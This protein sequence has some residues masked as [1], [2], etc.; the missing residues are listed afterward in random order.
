MY[1]LQKLLC[2]FLVSVLLAVTAYAADPYVRFGAPESIGARQGGF[3]TPTPL[4]VIVRNP[5]ARGENVLQSAG[6]LGQTGGAMLVNTARPEKSIAKLTTKLRYDRTQE[7]GSRLEVTVGEDKA[8]L[9]LYDWELRPLAEFVNSGHH[10]AIS[11]SLSGQGERIS[12][13][14][15]FEQQLLGLRFIQADLIARNIVLSQEFLP[16]DGQGL[17]LGAGEKARLGTDQS[18]TAAVTELTPLMSRTGNAAPFSVLTDA[19]LAFTFAIENGRFVVSG[20]PRYIFWHPNGN[21]VVQEVRVNA[22]L[23]ASWA[24]LKQANP[25]VIESMERSF[26]AVALFRFQKQKQLANWSAF[27]K[28][29]KEIRLQKVPTP[30]SLAAAQAGSLPLRTTP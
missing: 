23:N 30:T 17:I 28:Q 13:D 10:G 4:K 26:R 9:D 5:G 6:T 18:V 24:Q 29:T 1:R 14:A 16:R 2:P 25:L 21:R 22:E 19:D 7:D 12:L 8:A 20:T 27:V 11:I 3:E 15:A